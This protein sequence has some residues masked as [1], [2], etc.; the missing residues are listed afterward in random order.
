LA[1]WLSATF[2]LLVDREAFVVAAGRELAVARP[3]AFLPDVAVSLNNQSGRLSQ[4][5]R[6]EDALTAIDEAV[7]ILGDDVVDFQPKAAVRQV[8]DPRQLAQYG[9]EAAIVAG[10]RA[11]ARDAPDNVWREQVAQRRVVGGFDGFE[12]FKAREA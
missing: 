7:A 10:Q 12:H 2:G 3:D 1:R 11:A 8:V 4:L 6:R 5:G 9:V